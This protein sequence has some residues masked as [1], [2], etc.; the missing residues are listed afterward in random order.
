MALN[1]CFVTLQ[2]QADPYDQ[3]ARAAKNPNLE[4]LDAADL[5]YLEAFTA[6]GTFFTDRLCEV[7]KNSGTGSCTRLPLDYNTPFTE[8]P[9]A[10]RFFDAADT[11][12]VAKD[13][14][15]NDRGGEG[16]SHSYFLLL[17]ANQ[18][19]VEVSAN[20]ETRYSPDE[21][22]A[23]PVMKAAEHYRSNM[24]VAVPSGGG[25]LY[26]YSRVVVPKGTVMY[27]PIPMSMLDKERKWRKCDGEIASKKLPSGWMHRY[28]SG[29]NCGARFVVEVFGERSRKQVTSY[30]FR[31]EENF[32][33]GPRYRS[34]TQTYRIGPKDP[35]GFYTFEWWYAGKLL[36]RTRF[37]VKA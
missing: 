20:G 33:I 22:D 17:G 2:A 25:V 6:P 13:R 4:L 14:L 24:M 32:N 8:F 12:S 23:I 3:A 30:I 19:K 15:S 16:L 5:Q 21:I 36:T 28:G 9:V 10:L 18:G 35:P 37:E 29:G 7:P 34:L 11:Q 1:L 26:F 31:H 27:R